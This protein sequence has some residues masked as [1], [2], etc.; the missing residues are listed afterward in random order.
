MSMNASNLF[1]I[2][3]RGDPKLNCRIHGVTRIMTKV[4]K[5]RFQNLSA[6]QSYDIFVL[7]L[8]REWA[9]TDRFY[10]TIKAWKIQMSKSLTG[11]LEHARDDRY[12]RY[13]KRPW[14]FNNA[15]EVKSLVSDF[16]FQDHQSHLQLRSKINRT[17]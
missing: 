9:L 14:I 16:F 8:L 7:C 17:C 12:Y 4:S 3:H 15:P 6:F 13:Y 5:H 2:S 1:T 10:Y 11:P